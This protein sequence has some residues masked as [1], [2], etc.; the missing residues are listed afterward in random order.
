[1]THSLMSS[2][3]GWYLDDGTISDELPVL[4]DDINRILAF[5]EVSG[6]PLN[7]DKCEVFFINASVDDESHMFSEISKLLPG[8]KKVDESSFELLGSPIFESGLEKM[9]SSKVQSLISMC[10]RLQLLDVHPALCIFKSSLSHCRF[11]YFYCYSTW[12]CS[13]HFG[14][15]RKTKNR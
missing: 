13:E 7:T 10:D 12:K 14:N 5:C 2:L 4:L 15:F 11:S 9:I 1:M 6:L 8:I 3:N